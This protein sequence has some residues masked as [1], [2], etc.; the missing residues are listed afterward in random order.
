MRTILDT[1]TS[2]TRDLR[3]ST[4]NLLSS[5]EDTSGTAQLQLEGMK[6]ATEPLRA[7]LARAE[8]ENAN[9]V[10]FEVVDARFRYVKS[11][12]VILNPQIEI[13]VWNGTA[14]AIAT[15][16]FHAVLS[17]PGR[18]VP[19]VEGDL[20]ENTSGGLEPGESS[21]WKMR[22]GWPWSQAPQEGH[23]LERHVVPTYL[24]GAGGEPIGGS[25]TL[26]GSREL[27]QSARCSAAR[28]VE[29]AK[30]SVE[31]ARERLGSSP[32]GTRQEA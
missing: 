15:A 9:L 25:D 21:T 27:L 11:A 26:E 5:A 30:Q 19:W 14:Q 8:E 17:T 2:S 31:V 24:R 20:V 13:E 10:R 4:S 16:H 32:R 6:H 12:L 3:H 23:E 29:D 18:T 28:R 1:S 22:C 7:E